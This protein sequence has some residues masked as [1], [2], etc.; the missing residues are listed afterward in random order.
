MKMKHYLLIVFTIIAI[1]FFQPLIMLLGGLTL[2][3]AVTAFIYADLK[4]AAQDAFEKKAA[5]MVS[6]LRATLRKQPLPADHNTRVAADVRP[7]ERL[8][9][10]PV[11]SPETP[12]KRPT[13]RRNNKESDNALYN[14]A[15]P[16]L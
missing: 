11:D 10:D 5:L 6:Q 3:G 8:A 13:R 2:I 14:A 16:D 1:A 12:V 4:P 15:T 7:A 9:N